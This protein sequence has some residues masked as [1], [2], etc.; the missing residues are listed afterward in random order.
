MRAY[1]RLTANQSRKFES[2]KKFKTYFTVFIIALDIFLIIFSLSKLTYLEIFQ[3][4][5]IAVSGIRP[6]IAEQIKEKSR[7]ILQ[8]SYLGLFSK[9]N[10]FLYPKSQLIASTADLSSEIL[11]LSIHR[12]GILGLRFNITTKQSSAE[13]CASLPEV[14]FNDDFDRINSNCYLA[15][16]SGLMFERV[17]A[18]STKNINLYFIPS[19]GEMSTSTDLLLNKYATSTAEFTTLQ[20]FYNQSRESGL[21]PQFVLIKEDGEYEMY[22]KDTVIYFNNQ[23][24]LE[25][26]LQNLLLFYDRM[27]SEKQTDFE[28]IDVRFGSNVF[29]RQK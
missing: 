11:S 7:N 25:I 15:D 27:N 8:G 20:N 21:N 14:P 16:W 5:E 29:Y 4:K 3:I 23:S 6:Q 18:S 10:L 9:A 17:Q 1:S 26:Q 12:N 2:K 19:L 13:I 22:A 24:S 28:Y